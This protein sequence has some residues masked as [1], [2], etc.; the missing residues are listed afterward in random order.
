[1]Y[2]QN[3][4]FNGETYGIDMHYLSVYGYQVKSGRGFTQVDYDNFR[5]VALVDANTVSTLF[6]GEDPVGKSLEVKGDVFTVVGVDCSIQGVYS[7][8]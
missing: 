5:K 3:T 2:Y 6:G 8:H 7:D 4:G 1:M